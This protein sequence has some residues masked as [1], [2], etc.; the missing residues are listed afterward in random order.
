MLQIRCSKASHG[1]L[2]VCA[3]CCRKANQPDPVQS[4]QIFTSYGTFVI[5]GFDEAGLGEML[6]SIC[7]PLS[8]FVDCL[9]I[10]KRQYSGNDVDTAAP[11]HLV[12]VR[13]QSRLI[14]FPVESDC[15]AQILKTRLASKSSFKD[16]LYRLYLNG[17]ILKVHVS[18]MSNSIPLTRQQDDLPIS[19]QANNSFLFLCLLFLTSLIGRCFW[20]HY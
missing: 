7:V 2:D 18:I 3:N 9:M 4:V 15:T 16:E 8:R 13:I 1:I 20:Q 11:H 14:G 6:R 19:Q 17:N 5:Q 12:W 10:Y